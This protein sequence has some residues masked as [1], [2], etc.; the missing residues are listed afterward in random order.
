MSNVDY[1]GVADLLSREEFAESVAPGG[2]YSDLVDLLWEREQRK[3]RTDPERIAQIEEA[4]R[5]SVRT[6]FRQATNRSQDDRRP[7]GHASDGFT[8]GGNYPLRECAASESVVRDAFRAQSH[9]PRP[10][11]GEREFSRR[12]D[13]G[14]SSAREPD[15]PWRPR[16][17]E[18]QR[19]P[20][21]GGWVGRPPG[22]VKVQT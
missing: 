20:G 16:L 4:E 10:D 6:G 12:L 17:H 13:R 14:F 9:V 18:I 22:W 11:V 2:E 19:V 3:R 15:S 8:G 21:Y 1:F 5:V 7:P